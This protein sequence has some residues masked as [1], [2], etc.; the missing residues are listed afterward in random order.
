MKR[1]T[2]IFFS[3]QY[4]K[5][6]WREDVKAKSRKEAREMMERNDANLIVITE[7]EYDRLF[8]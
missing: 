3:G 1:Y 7:K 2:G 5:P 8:G 6:V 4:K